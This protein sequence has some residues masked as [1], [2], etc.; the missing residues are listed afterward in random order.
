MVTDMGG[1]GELL[2]SL[3]LTDLA[4]PS[5]LALSIGGNRDPESGRMS[6]VMLYTK[7]YELC[8]IVKV[9]T[10]LAWISL[11]HQNPIEKNM[12][13]TQSQKYQ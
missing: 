1:S 11:F 3:D 8:T 7:M 12:R 2:E 5:L 10:L 13:N 4:E 9:I 6:S